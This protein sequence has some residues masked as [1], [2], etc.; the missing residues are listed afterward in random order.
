MKKQLLLCLYF[1]IISLTHAQDKA[2]RIDSLLTAYSNQKTFNGNVLIAEKGIV[3]FKKSYGYADEETKRKL[4]TETVFELASVSKQFTAMSIVLLQKQGKLSYDDALQK[5]VPELNFYKPITIRNLLLHTSGL[6]D[7]ME[8][9]TEHWDKSKFATNQNIVELFAKHQPKALF[10]PNEKFEY[11][12]TGY[13]LLGLI[14]EKVSKQSFGDYLKA[15]IFKPLQMNHTQVYRSRYQPEV[16]QNYANGYVLDEKNNKVKPDTFGKEF[17]TYY[18]DGIV[19]DG[20]VNSTLDDL[21]K[22]DRAL[23]SHQL[24]QDADKELLFSSVKTLDGRNTNYG[25]GWVIS[26]HPKYGKS[27]SHTGSWAGYLTAITRFLT[28]DKTII[29]LQNNLTQTTKMPVEEIKR[30]LYNEKSL[31]DKV[32]NKIA[33]TTADLDVYLGEYSSAEFPLKVTITKDNTTMMAQATGQSAFPLNAIEKNKFEFKRAGILLEFI[34]DEK[35]MILNQG[36]KQFT[37][38]KP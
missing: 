29:I 32:E 17:Y 14:I 25:F 33:L 16:I 21:L 31:V 18:L 12:N 5:Y 9:F 15:A 38:V 28:D 11:S 4:N 27:V 22:W 6:P 20:M 30:I 26:Q 1:I 2:Q 36:G 8:L 23:Y 24:V 37:F 7:Y 34:P 19:G 13:A 3:L 35:K 10:Q